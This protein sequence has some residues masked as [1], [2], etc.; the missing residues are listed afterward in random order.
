[1]G[2]ARRHRRPPNVEDPRRFTDYLYRILTDGRLLD[3]LYQFVTDKEYAKRYIEGVLG[4]GLT[5][6]TRAV[7]RTDEEVDRLTIDRVPCVL[8]PTHASGRVLFHRDPS[9]FIDKGRLKDW[10]RLRY[11]AAARESN[12][13]HLTPKIMVEEFF[14]D[15]VGTVPK[16][17]KVFCFGGAPRMIEV[18]S[19]RPDDPRGNFYDTHWNRLQFTS[20]YPAGPQDDRPPLLAEILDLAARL[21][22][23]FPFVRVDFYAS[24]TEIRIGELTFCPS[25]A[26][27][28]IRPDNAD[29]DIGRLFSGRDIVRIRGVDPDRCRG[30]G[31]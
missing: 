12:Y 2:F 6:E 28:R 17:Y 14:A 25:A 22:T 16:D 5:P 1:M 31:Q 4:P 21:A 19:G 7:L 24:T 3:P 23:P 30:G 26:N 11:Y 15:G 29:I 27:A 9:D 8:K 20:S 18:V 10:L 13:R